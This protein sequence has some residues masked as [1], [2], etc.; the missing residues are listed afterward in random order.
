[1]PSLTGILHVYVAF[2]W[3]EE[4]D[5]ELAR[6]SIPSEVQELPRRRRTPPS[7]TYRPP[8]LRIP[9]PPLETTLAE[10]G[11]CRMTAEATVFDF[12]GVSVDLHVPFALSP[13]SLLRLAGGLAE[14]GPLVQQAR[15][16][17]SSLF[18]RLQ[19][20]I[21]RQHWLEN[22]SEEYFVFQLPPDACLS[23]QQLFKERRE[24]LAGLLRLDDGPLSENEVREALERVL[25]YSPDDLFLPDWAC[26]VLVDRDCEETLQAIEL[27]N[28]QLLEYRFIDD[29]LDDSMRSAY[30][31]IH[32]FTRT[33]LPFWRSHARSLRL[34]GELEVEAT[35]WFERTGNV[36][37]LV[38]DQ[39]L[40]R[41]YKHLA[42]RFHLEEWEENIRR[43]LTVLGGI[44][45]VLSDQTTTFRGEFLEIIVVL[46]IFIEIVLALFHR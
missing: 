28:L 5:L 20:A 7:I 4:I 15:A 36:L 10:L 30:Q 23:A 19:P 8:P 6:R 41:V 45:Q 44:Y 14:P 3:G 24:W 9:L 2:D 11:P 13:D 22:F 34:V 18:Q 29:R 39:Y 43:K 38:G 46:L 35:Q 33:W 32:R 17:V 31:L 26:A 12:A 42:E 40:A 16:L 27:A 37:K 21:R 1:M 25:S